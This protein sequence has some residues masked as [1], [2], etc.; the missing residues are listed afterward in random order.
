M[1]AVL[2]VDPKVE[3]VAVLEGLAEAGPC[4]ACGPSGYWERASA[5]GREHEACRLFGA[6]GP[7]DWRHR[8]PALVILDFSPPP[9]L[10]VSV[11]AGHYGR[12][13]GQDPVSRLLPALRAFCREGGFQKFF[14]SERPFYESL[15]EPLRES[16]NR[17]DIEAPVFDYLGMRSTV[18]YHFILSPLYHGW[19]MHNVL[20]P[21]ADGSWD[22]YTISGHSRVENGRPRAELKP[23]ILINAWHE[24]C[25]TL[26]DRVTQS[27]RGALE[28]L[29]GLYA[30]MS[31]T[32]K[33]KY[34]GPPGWL[35]MVDEHVIRAITA[36][37]AAARRGEEEGL[38][39]LSREKKEGFALIGP[40]YE[41]LKEYEAARG[42]YPCLADFYPRIIELLRRVRGA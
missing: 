11:S 9:A 35:H 31:G 30:L 18:R 39:C 19:A 3:L 6:M 21:G 8:H 26:V 16:L 37:L 34:Q 25:H 20:H 5:L 28:P 12:Q 33:N 27:H 40:V 32:A 13:A 15:L 7:G 29:S 24:V 1:P 14:D 42:R 10:E 36:R 17:L 2:E 38:L 41:I 22:I 23:D 4:A